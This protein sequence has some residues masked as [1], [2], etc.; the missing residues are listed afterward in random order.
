MGARKHK[1]PDIQNGAKALTPTGICA[2]CTNEEEE[3][4]VEKNWC[5][6]ENTFYIEKNIT[7][8]ILP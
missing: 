7:L 3:F 6:E 5:L 8:I 2:Q 1:C 4:V